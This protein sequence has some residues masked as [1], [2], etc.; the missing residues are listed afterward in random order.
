MK[1][2]RKFYEI[3]ELHMTVSVY[4]RKRGNQTGFLCQGNEVP[5]GTLKI[6]YTLDKSL[7]INVCIVI[8]VSRTLESLF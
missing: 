6:F 4:H 8:K 5:Q 3:H 2:I 1:K 7:P